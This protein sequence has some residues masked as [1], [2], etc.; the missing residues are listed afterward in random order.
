MKAMKKIILL[1]TLFIGICM[2][3]S[4]AC[5]CDNAYNEEQLDKK[6]YSG[7][8]YTFFTAEILAIESAFHLEVTVQIKHIY[9]GAKFVKDSL[10]PITI[11]FDLR[12]ECAIM[13]RGDIKAGSNLFITAAYNSMGKMFITNHCDAF[14]PVELIDTYNLR[15][16][17]EDLKDIQ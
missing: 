15:A 12:T 14:F 1:S 9:Y 4:F 2:S 6:I 11:Y 8:N 10:Q 3:S 16:Y 5:G 17:L 7:A 13:E